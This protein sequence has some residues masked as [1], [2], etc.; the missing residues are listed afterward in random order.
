M[1][2]LRLKLAKV[3]GGGEQDRASLLVENP[4]V[5]GARDFAVDYGIEVV[6]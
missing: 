4:Q 3:G 5:D 2:G 1:H 6:G